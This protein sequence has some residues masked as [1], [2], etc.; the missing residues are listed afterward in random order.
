MG[1]RGVH[2]TGVGSLGAHSASRRN[3][4]PALVALGAVAYLVTN[5]APPL[6]HHQCTYCAQKIT[7]TVQYL[8][9]WTELQKMPLKTSWSFLLA[10][11]TNALV[12]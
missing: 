8:R 9:T 4:C 12:Y 7:Y 5:T 3:V 10:M 2:S 11:L 1:T 6:T